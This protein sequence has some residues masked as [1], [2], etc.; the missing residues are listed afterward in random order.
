MEF[1][2]E[3]VSCV[4]YVDGVFSFC[5][6]CFL[7]FVYG[8]IVLILFCFRCII[9]GFIFVD[10]VIVMWNLCLCIRGFIV[11]DLFLKFFVLFNFNFIFCSIL[12]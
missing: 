12:N 6:F 4:S 10:V 7:E 3:I 8:S 1:V 2:S 5:S 9:L 11:L